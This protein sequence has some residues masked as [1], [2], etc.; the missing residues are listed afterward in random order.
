[1]AE[2]MGTKGAASVAFSSHGKINIRL[3][4]GVNLETVQNIVARIANLTGCLSCGFLGI[5]LTLGGDPV[6]FKQLGQLPGVKQVSF[7][8]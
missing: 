6:E 7:G 3:A 8:G 4:D 5:D 2:S 1:M